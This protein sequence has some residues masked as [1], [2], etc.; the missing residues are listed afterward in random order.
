MANMVGPVFAIES[1]TEAGSR[2]VQVTGGGR[3]WTP[4]G[5][6]KDLMLGAPGGTS[7]SFISATPGGRSRRNHGCRWICRSAN[8]VF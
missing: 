1:R 2:P 5:M 4:S 7:R 3:A 8:H 6:Q